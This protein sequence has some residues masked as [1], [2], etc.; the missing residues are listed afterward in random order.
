MNRWG[1]VSSLRVFDDGSRPALYIGGAF[2]SVGPLDTY[3]IAKW[4]GIRWSAVG[5]G[6]RH[7]SVRT[8]TDYDDG[9]GPTL[10][11]GGGFLRAAGRASVRIAKWRCLGDLLL[12]DLN[13]D[14]VIDE[15]DIDPFVLALVSPTTYE[16]A[17]PHCDIRTGD[18]NYDGAVNAFDIDPFVRLLA[19]G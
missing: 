2:E 9:S 1:G 14:G 8:L 15:F 5:G 6:I 3:G 11:A 18:C 17:Y 7:G 4:D 13:C 19:G 12:G 16:V 10:Y